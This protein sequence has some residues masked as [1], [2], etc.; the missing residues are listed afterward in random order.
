MKLPSDWELSGSNIPLEDNG[1]VSAAN[2]VCDL[3]SVSFVV[4]KEDVHLL[5]IAD[6]ELLEA[7]GK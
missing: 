1:A 4:H 7:I 2:I 5:D 6:K 3:C